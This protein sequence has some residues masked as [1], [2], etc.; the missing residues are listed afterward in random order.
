MPK[1]KGYSATDKMDEKFELESDLRTLVRAQEI[2]K[3]KTRLNKV[4]TFAKQQAKEAQDMASN[5]DG[6]RR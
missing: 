3:N 5:L 1:G 6:L 2:M 4:L